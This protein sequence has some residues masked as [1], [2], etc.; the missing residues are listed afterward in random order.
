MKTEVMWLIRVSVAVI[1]G[2]IL[3]CVSSLYLLASVF[4]HDKKELLRCQIG[5][6]L[7]SILAHIFLGGISGLITI[8]IALLRNIL[9]YY[10]SKIA[11]ATLPLLVVVGVLLNRDGLWGYIPICAS[12][13]Y[14]F[15]LIKFKSVRIIKFGLISN[16]ILWSIYYLHL[17]SILN[18]FTF[19]VVI[20]ITMF[21][22]DNKQSKE[23]CAV[24]TIVESE[25][26]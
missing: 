14:T 12:L 7:F 18:V 3:A 1:I 4:K 17:Q 25:R 9:T 13:S 22:L 10:G 6:L 5:D 24:S 8:S 16:L 20:G 26:E 23:E 15:I 19:A 2:N 21:N 11:Y